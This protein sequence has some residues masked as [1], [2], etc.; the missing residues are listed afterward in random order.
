M[1]RD[2]LA[3]L[4]KAVLHDH[5]DGGVRVGTV[6][7]LAAE[8][9]YAALPATDVEELR[10]WFHQG[11]SGSLEAYLASFVHTVGVM[12]TPAALTRVAYEA[13][14]DLAADGVVYAESRFA[15]L[16]HTSGGMTTD[17]V[18]AAV[19]D[20]IGR[21]TADTGITV[22][23][24][25]ASMRDRPDSDAVADLAVAW[26]DR[27]VVAFDLVGPEAGYP[28]DDHLAACRRARERNLGLTIHAGESDGPNS[29]WR[30][31]ARCGAE[32]IGHGVRI[33]EDT[34]VEDGDIVAVGRVAAMVRDHRVP[35][36][37][38]ISSNL[39]T[40][41]FPTAAAHPIGMLHR[42]GFT[43]TLNTDN[44][45]M[46]GV[47]LSDEFALA[48]EHHGFGPAD[49]LEITENALRAGFGDWPER[50]R[51]LE[52][53]VRPAYRAAGAGG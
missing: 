14:V 5:L 4:P 40:G 43:V 28:P 11:G 31:V 17:E 18:M 24:I 48:V 26:M 46:S 32:R 38:C 34:T 35:L 30:A 22:G 42:A 21:G 8:Q 41:A 33:V 23:L 49:L 9:G 47:S 36:E 2:L 19:V 16:L 6:V 20:G 29:V 50:K 12:Q 10:A 13:V 15:P 51:L 25:V 37:V 45:L 53:V 1:D 27:G 44:R 7:D 3:S 52:E 39:H